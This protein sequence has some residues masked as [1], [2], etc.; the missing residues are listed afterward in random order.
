VGRFADVIVFDEK[1]IADHATY[2]NPTELST[3]MQFVVVNGKVVIDQGKYVPGLLP[4]RVLKHVA[5]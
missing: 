3:G 4:G 2:V 5:K 1:T